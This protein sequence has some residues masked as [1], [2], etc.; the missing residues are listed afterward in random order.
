[1]KDRNNI[2]LKKPVKNGQ[3]WGIIIPCKQTK[4]IKAILTETRRVHH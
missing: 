2:C 3:F 1:M 4:Q